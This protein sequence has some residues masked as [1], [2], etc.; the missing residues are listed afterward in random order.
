MWQYS[1]TRLSEPSRISR[2][3]YD[4]GGEG[5]SNVADEASEIVVSKRGVACAI[6]LWVDYACR[7]GDGDS[8]QTV[9]TSSP[10]GQQLVR[11][12]HEPVAVEIGDKL[13]I[14]VRFGKDQVE[15][16]ALDIKMLPRKVE[17]PRQSNP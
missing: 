6:E 4:G 13:S 12:L 11:K 10:A 14:K 3:G 5:H 15:S 9:S 8:F 1:L 17:K 2:L 16:Y 7:I